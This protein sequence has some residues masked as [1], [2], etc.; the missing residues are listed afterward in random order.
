MLANNHSNLKEKKK[1]RFK[2]LKEKNTKLVFFDEEVVI[3]K[4]E[5]VTIISKRIT[6][7]NF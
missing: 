2:N 6:S 1:V 7:Y 3:Y 4:G 5:R